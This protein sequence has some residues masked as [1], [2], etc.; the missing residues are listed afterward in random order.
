V[1]R[2]EA[3][4]WYKRVRSLELTDKNRRKEVLRRLASRHA[5]QSKTLPRL[6]DLP[7][8]TPDG[9]Y[10]MSRRVRYSW[11]GSASRCYF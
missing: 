7:T 3:E 5:Y 1:T 11:N 10:D 2:T 8:L 4:R 6:W 9:E